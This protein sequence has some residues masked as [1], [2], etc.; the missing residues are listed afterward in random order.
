MRECKCC[1]TCKYKNVLHNELPC[2]NCLRRS[3]ADE[4]E[5]KEDKEEEKAEE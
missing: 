3:M 1:A 5:P 2:I 4:W